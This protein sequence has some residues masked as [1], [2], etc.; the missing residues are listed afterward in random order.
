M[1][2]LPQATEDGTTCTLDE[3]APLVRGAMSGMRLF[4]D[5]ARMGYALAALE[6]ELSS[7]A[8][9]GA[10]RRVRLGGTGGALSARSSPIPHWPTTSSP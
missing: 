6:G 2:R 8:I 5:G 3:P 10:R 1:A 9:H 7:A 4:I